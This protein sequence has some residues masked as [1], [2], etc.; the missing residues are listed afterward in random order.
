MCPAMFA[1]PF[2]SAD[3]YKLIDVNK[4]NT[5]TPF[6]IYLFMFWNV[7]L[8]IKLIVMFTFCAT[9]NF[10]KKKKEKPLQKC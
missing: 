4:Q 10:T 3:V 1:C 8:C 5:N 6:I 7:L 2:T 9:V